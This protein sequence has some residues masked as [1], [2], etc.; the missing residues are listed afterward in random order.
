MTKKEEIA[1]WKVKLG[2]NL[3]WA[4]KGM[5]AIYKNQTPEEKSQQSTLESNGLGFTGYDS[6][7]LT[8]IA[9][10]YIKTGGL[11]LG[12]RKVLLYRMPKYASQLHK[13]YGEKK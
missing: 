9:E 7:I 2:S 4:V 13:Q 12:D 3:G 5:L 1:A 8:Q 10:R 11:Y 6:A